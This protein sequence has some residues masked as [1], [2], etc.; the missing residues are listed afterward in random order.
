M[1]W[2]TEEKA[3]EKWCPMVRIQDMDDEPA[4][5]RLRRTTGCAHDGQH[6]S[7]IGSDCAMWVWGDVTY[8]PDG[9]DRG[10]CGLRVLR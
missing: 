2:H 5:N 8:R 3:R 10:G 4:V 9:R 1:N 6:L 7:C